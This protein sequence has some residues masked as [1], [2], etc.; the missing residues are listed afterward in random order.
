MTFP[1]LLDGQDE[2][3]MGTHAI[4]CVYKVDK[5]YYTSESIPIRYSNNP[6][7]T[8]WLLD[9]IHVLQVYFTCHVRIK[10]PFKLDSS[11]LKKLVTY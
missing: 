8:S 3:D 10:Q 5:E 9:S 4:S 1:L 2:Q 11:A 6:Q 7:D